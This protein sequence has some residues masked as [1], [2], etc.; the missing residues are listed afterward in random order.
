MDFTNKLSESE[1][2]ALYARSLQNAERRLMNLLVME[3]Y[4][5]DTFD[6]TTFTPHDG[7]TPGI[8]R[9]GEAEIAFVLDAISKIKAKIV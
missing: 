9:Q 3:G 8:P 2:R 1:Q 7:V 4:D 5:P 6:E